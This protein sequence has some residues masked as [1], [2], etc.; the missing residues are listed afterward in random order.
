MARSGPRWDGGGR[1]DDGGRGDGG[2][3]RVRPQ[4]QHQHQHQHQHFYQYQPN[5]IAGLAM[6]MTAQFNN[7]NTLIEG[8]F[9][10]MRRVL[11]GL[12]GF[13]ALTWALAVIILLIAGRLQCN[14]LS[15]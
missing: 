13:M 1:G 7:M 11:Q 9:D 2:P 4:Q 5:S 8:Q 6:Q 12:R 3:H 15:F 10:D 14:A